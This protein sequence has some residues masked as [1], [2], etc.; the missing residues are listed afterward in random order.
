MDSQ[1]LELADFFDRHVRDGQVPTGQRRLRIAT[2]GQNGLQEVNRWPPADTQDERLALHPGREL[3][4]ADEPGQALQAQVAPVSSAGTGLLNRWWTQLDSDDI[5]YG[6]RSPPSST[7]LHFTGPALASARTLQGSPR[8]GLQLRS[9]VADAAV[10]VLLEA[11][12]PDGRGIYLSEALLRLSHRN[13][14]APDPAWPWRLARSFARA[15]RQPMPLDSTQPVELQMF[16]V[17]ARIPAGYRLRLVVMA[18]DAPTFAPLTPAGAPLALLS[19][20]GQAS[21]LSLPWA[22]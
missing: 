1:F 21:V 4:A 3:M 16:P 9:Q 2:M 10:H 20:P 15:D 17:V 19:G 22:R 13:T 11:V 6:D 18:E 14:A 8:V 7:Q 12:A 5:D